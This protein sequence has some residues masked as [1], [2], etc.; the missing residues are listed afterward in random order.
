MVTAQL[1][2]FNLFNVTRFLKKKK[3]RDFSINRAR[4]RI[5]ISYRWRRFYRY[6]FR[7]YRTVYNFNS[8][9]KP[10][11]NIRTFDTVLGFIE[12][13]SACASYR[14]NVRRVQNSTIRTQHYYK[15]VFVKRIYF[16]WMY[17]ILRCS[18]NVYEYSI[19]IVENQTASISINIICCV[20][21]SWRRANIPLFRICG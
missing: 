14:E 9:R 1:V 19:G 20:R 8:L 12:T 5:I 10:Y 17:W 11:Y 4:I 3:K 6:Y 13:L 21:V 15:Y 7:T 16:S 2:L 18:N